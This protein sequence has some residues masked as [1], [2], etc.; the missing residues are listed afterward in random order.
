MIAAWLMLFPG[1][2]ASAVP[3]GTWLSKP[4]IWFHRSTNTLSQVME[5]I[6]GQR[7]KIVFL[8][9]RNVS[10]AV[11]RQ[12]SQEARRHGLIPIVWIQ[13]PQYR[14]LTV[15]QLMHEA[16]HGDGM[17]VDDHFFAHYSLRHFYLLHEN[18]NKPIFCSIQPFQAAKVPRRGCTQ[19]DVQCYTPQTFSSCIKLAD[20]LK[21]VTSLSTKNTLRYRGQLG[22][23]AF[24]VFLWPH[25]N[26]Y[27]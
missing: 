13:S 19:L 20:Q 23:R 21:A 16:R 7:Y 22:G 3:N 26:E 18:Y 27:R 6:K 17:Q 24:N 10:D 4:Q 9:Y 12:V 2:A 11:Q 8:D 5:R 14:S 1:V 15:Q 25:T